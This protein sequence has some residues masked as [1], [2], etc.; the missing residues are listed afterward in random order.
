MPVK[1]SEN[2]VSITSDYG[3]IS[4]VMNSSVYFDTYYKILGEERRYMPDL[5]DP[6]L[7]KAIFIEGCNR[8]LQEYQ[9][10]IDRILAILNE[11][12]DA[13]SNEIDSLIVNYRD[14]FEPENLFVE[15]YS[16]EIYYSYRAR[17]GPNLKYVIDENRFY[18]GEIPIND[19]YELK[20][21]V[22][23]IQDYSFD[24]MMS[25]SS[26]NYSCSH[27]VSKPD[28]D[29]IYAVMLSCDDLIFG[30]VG[31]VF[32]SNKLEIIKNNKSRFANTKSANLRA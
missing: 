2:S 22:S 1:V 29:M 21:V 18:Y 6:N 3:R 23:D 4:M 16:N 28:F 14:D 9:Y 24:L 8:D 12:E 27:R 15:K 31:N 26:I 30:L 11:A 19:D 32:R 7:D 17:D 25:E 20:K 13:I 5:L 10:E